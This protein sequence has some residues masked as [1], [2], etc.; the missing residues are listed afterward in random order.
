MESAPATET[1]REVLNWLKDRCYTHVLVNWSEVR[2]LASTY[3]FSPPVDASEL[4]RRFD[5]LSAAGLKR[6]HKFK[7][8]DV[9][10][11]YVELYK[12]KHEN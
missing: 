1:E 10:G 7:H 9:H 8:R 6:T 11:R 3:G 5:R 12:L 4:E 2:R